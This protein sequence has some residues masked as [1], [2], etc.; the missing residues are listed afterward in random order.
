MGRK[1]IMSVYIYRDMER[2]RKRHMHTCTAK[3][4]LFKKHTSLVLLNIFLLSFQKEVLFWAR[5]MMFII[6]LLSCASPIR[7]PRWYSS[8]YSYSQVALTCWCCI[9]VYSNYV[10]AVIHY[11][12]HL[13]IW[14]IFKSFN[15]E[16]LC[17]C[18][19]AKYLYWHQVFHARMQDAF[20]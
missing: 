12:L 7:I 14:L 17:F 15:M 6:I 19:L 18:P 9:S 5:S 13:F 8:G 3:W 16:A 11:Y 4:S 2:E 20:W 1:E 10:S